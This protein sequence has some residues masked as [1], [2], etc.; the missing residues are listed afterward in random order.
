M[1]AKLT[2]TIDE[3]LVPV[4]KRHAGMRG[5]SLSQIV[6]DALRALAKATTPDRRFSSRWRGAFTPAGKASPRYRMLAKR[7]L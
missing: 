7:Y 2:L 4:A 6:E 5:V 3:A 1:K